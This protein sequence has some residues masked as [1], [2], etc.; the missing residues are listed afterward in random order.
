MPH[1]VENDRLDCCLEQGKSRSELRRLIASIDELHPSGPVKC[2]VRMQQRRRNVAFQL[3]DA[4]TES[5]E[6]EGLRAERCATPRELTRRRQ[7]ELVR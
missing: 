5:G 6:D 2:P 4:G 7:T 3:E 1:L